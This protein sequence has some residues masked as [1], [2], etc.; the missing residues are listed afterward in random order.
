MHG[1]D[2]VN[3]VRYPI[4]DAEDPRRIGLMTRL[5][6][7]LETRQYCTLPDF[8]TAPALE[9]AAA[10]AVALRPAAFANDARRNCYLQRQGD[11][12]LPADHPRN[13]ML[14]A[15]TRMVA[16]DQIPAPS[17]LKALYHWD[18]V[19][20][21]VAGIVGVPRLFPNE[22]PYQ[23]VN[24]LCYEPGD[25]SAWHFDS[26]NAFT[27]T[28]M[29]QAPDSGGAFEL[30]PGSRSDADPNEAFLTE[31]LAGR[32]PDA[33]VEVAR[34]PGTLCIFR[35]CHA[36]HRVAPVSGSRMRIMGVFVYETEPGVIGD[37]E[38]NETVY[39]PRAALQR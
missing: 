36:L 34:E 37:P 1:A 18:A 5:R 22:D 35:G 26:D 30:V 24:V 13:V 9:L 33:V 14:R 39:G 10:Q 7:E 38:V 27:M 3:L 4:A 16:C 31:V 28:L 29:L 21:F 17:P 2:V 23:P 12:A 6:A 32:R 20:T 25:E 15:S 11:P 8:V 19:R